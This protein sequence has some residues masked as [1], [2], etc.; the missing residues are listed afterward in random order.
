MRAVRVGMLGLGTVGGGTLAVLRRNAEE[1][2]RRA[3][4]AIEVT[5]AVVREPARA[6]QVPLEGLRVSADPAHVVD[7]P[8]IDIVCELMGGTEPA[9]SL[10]LRALARGKPVV[11]ANKALIATHGNEV[12]AAA[13]DAGLMVA[14]EAAVAGGIPIIKTLREGMA[15]NRIEGLAGIINGTCNFI[16]SAMRNRGLDF[17]QALTEAQ[18]LGYAEADPA[19]DIE[20]VDAAHKLTIL[21]SI[22][23]GIPLDCAR[24]H[25]EGITGVHRADV[26]HAAELGYRVKLLGIARRGPAGIE[27]RVHPTLVP[28]QQLIANVEGVLNA[29]LVQGDALGSLLLSGAGAG[30]EATASAV[31]ADLVDVVRVST[32]DPHNRVPHLAFQP[33]YIVAQ[34]IV[35]MD[36][37]RCPFYLR[38]LAEDRP[39]VLADVARIFAEHDISLEVVLQKAPSGHHRHVPI[40][41]VSSRVR[42]RA[43]RDALAR[44]ADLPCIR[45][46]VISIRIETFTP[47]H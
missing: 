17:D 26:E 10:V 12:F 42:E 38:M 13:R 9:R 28:A 5:H 47:A 35:P 15:G 20:G 44:V 31:V 16:L 40:V 21:A 30:A 41:F 4:R 39:G 22:A 14:F 45:G 29:V 27:L 3:G 43:L 19:F 8:D 34:T 46:D 33:E 1:I 11:T 24:V 37:V 23:F 36:E 2:S 6:R 32:A 18:A 25:V 7:N